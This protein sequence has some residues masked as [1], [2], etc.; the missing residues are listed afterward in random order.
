M[1]EFIEKLSSPRLLLRRF[2]LL[3]QSL[4]CSDFLFF[5]WF[6]LGSLH[7]FRNLFIP[8]RLSNL[9][10][11]HVVSYDL[12]YFC[13]IGCGVFSFIYS[14][15]YMNHLFFLGLSS[16]G[17]IYFIF[18]KKPALS[19]VDLFYYLFNPYFIY[20]LL[21]FVISL[22]FNFGIYLFFF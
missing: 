14:F 2:K 12:L 17:F 15:T 6:S 4:V 1:V 8:S 20:F 3:I 11:V 21:I 16:W 5:S 19:F 22:P 10:I 9:L 18:Q 7:V 13:C